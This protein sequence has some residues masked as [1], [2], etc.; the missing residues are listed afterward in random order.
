MK[1]NLGALLKETS[2]LQSEKLEE[3]DDAPLTNREKSKAYR[4][5]FKTKWAKEDCY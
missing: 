1:R 4:N 3:E 2:Q 5:W